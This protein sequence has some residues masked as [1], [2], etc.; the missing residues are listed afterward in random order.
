MSNLDEI[1][2][3]KL[4]IAKFSEKDRLDFVKELKRRKISHRTTATAV[5]FDERYL[6]NVR[7][8][9]PASLR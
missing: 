4:S 1:K 6:K 9:I 7:D 3:Q 2:F 5:L 8:L